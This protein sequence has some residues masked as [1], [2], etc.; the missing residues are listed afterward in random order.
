MSVE[1]QNRLTGIQHDNQFDVIVVGG[2]VNGIGVYR[3]LSLQGL[4]VLLVERNDYASGCS[5]APS[6]MIHGGLR[7]LE[8]GEF[9]LVR[10]S[11]QERDALLRNAPHLVA[12]LPTVIPVTSIFSGILN[13]AA[14]FF[15]WEGKPSSRGALPIKMGLSLYD[16]VTRKNQILP[17]HHFNSGQTTRDEWP[18]LTEQAIFSAVYYDAWISHPE[19]LCIEMISDVAETSPHSI[20]MNYA[21]LGLEEE[22]YQLT[23]RI[24]GQKLHVNARA[25]VHATGAWLDSSVKSLGSAP[26]EKMV[27]GT[28]GS[29]LIIDNPALEKALNGHMVYFENSDGRVC[30]VFPYLGKVLAGSTDI[31]VDHARRVRCEEEELV[32]ILDSLKLV[33]PAI[34]IRQD[35]VVFSYAGIRPLPQSKHEFTGRI[36]RGHDV[37][38]LPG[39]KLQFCMVGGKWT[40]FRAFAEQTTDQVLEALGRERQCD[41]LDLAIGGGKEFPEDTTSLARQLE[42]DFSI[43]TERARHLITHYGSVAGRVQQACNNDPGDCS[44]GEGSLYSRSEIKY[45]IRSEQVETLSDLVLRRTTLAITGK[46]SSGLIGI[47]AEILKAELGLSSKDINEQQATLVAEMTEFYGVTSQMLTERTELWSKKCA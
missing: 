14:S 43:D 23:C 31:R 4:R 44:V 45:M 41:T 39:D 26:A 18:E 19:R 34:D 1:R 21:E 8:N 46:I 42:R 15:G 33:F 17:N 29:H 12:P 28:K 20:A 9:D 24:T 10:E 27:S 40:T 47:L 32:Y 5:A 13:S 36:S 30:I 38:Q 22:E 16:W 37:R 2:G 25:V 11:L 7:Y 35:E 6:R 3:E